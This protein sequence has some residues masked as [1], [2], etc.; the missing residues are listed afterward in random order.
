MH[1]GEG[2][3][4]RE[5]EIGVMYPQVKE[6]TSHQELHDAHASQGTHPASPQSQTSVQVTQF[7]VLCHS[8]PRKFAGS[9]LPFWGRLVRNWE[10]SLASGKDIGR[11][12][13]SSSPL[14]AAEGGLLTI[15]PEKEFSKTHMGERVIFICLQLN[16]CVSKVPFP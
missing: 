9:F 4:D 11:T 6:A 16:P 14:G 15:S 12:E 13:G 5:A 7:M 2:H 8:G 1:T 3:V 10:Y